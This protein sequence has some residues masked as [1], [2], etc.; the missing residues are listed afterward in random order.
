MLHKNLEN[1]TNTSYNPMV[2]I[3][4]KSQFSQQNV[5]ISWKMSNF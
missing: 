1:F 2:E 3:H 4:R 5:F